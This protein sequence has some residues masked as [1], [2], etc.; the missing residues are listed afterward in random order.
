MHMLSSEHWKDFFF[1]LNALILYECFSCYRWKVE[2]SKCV[3]TPAGNEAIGLPTLLD[4]DVAHFWLK[5]I[6]LIAIA[7]E[8]ARFVTS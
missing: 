6:R 8:E 5:R 1:L 4:A 2:K 3:Q 7:V